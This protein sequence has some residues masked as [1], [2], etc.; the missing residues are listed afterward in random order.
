MWYQGV[1]KDGKT[2]WITHDLEMAKNY[3]SRRGEGAKINVFKPE[4]VG[5]GAFADAEGNPISPHEYAKQHW[6]TTIQSFGREMPEPFA[7]LDVQGNL[8]K[9]LGLK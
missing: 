6:A 3:A 5:E 7:V 2:Q 8:L 1:A 9:L 4:Q